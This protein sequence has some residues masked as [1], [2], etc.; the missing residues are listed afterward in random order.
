MALSILTFLVVS[1]LILGAYWLAVVRTESASKASVKGRL[2]PPAKRF[3]KSAPSVVSKEEHLSDIPAFSVLLSTQAGLAGRLRALLDQAGLP[4]TVGRLVLACAVAAVAGFA[5]LRFA[6]NAV[7]VSAI[8]G[9]VAGLAP[10]YYVK[11]RARKRM[12]RFEELFPEAI[13]LIVR[14]LRAGHA[15]T[16]GLAMAAEE[17]GEPVGPEF[18]LTYDHQNFG[19]PIDDA[20]RGLAQRIPLLDVQFFATAVLTQREAG[21]NLAEILENIVSVMRDRFKVKRQVRVVTAHARITGSVL[22]IIPPAVAAAMLVIAPQHM[23]TLWTD[24]LGVRLIVVAVV[25][26]VIGAIAI[27]KLVDIRY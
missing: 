19:M 18:R 11:H 20:L 23:R 24:P 10:Y 3:P 8:L 13:S 26:Q 15:F 7:L 12:L 16:T 27:R 2:K 25:L 9:L 4:W 1:T 14:A 21:G 6:T 22:A 17:I 5:V